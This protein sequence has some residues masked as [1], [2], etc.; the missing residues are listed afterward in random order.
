M[1]TVWKPEYELGI[2]TLDDDHKILVQHMNELETA[3]LVGQGKKALPELFHNLIEYTHMHFA[4]EEKIMQDRKFA[5]LAQHKKE[6]EEFLK[7]LRKFQQQ[8]N[9]GNIAVS[10]DVLNL[11]RDWLENHMLKSDKKLV[12][13]FR[14]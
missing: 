5:G 3:M 6:H 8:F 7:K 11:L 13:S 10:V 14:S 1:I 4:K 12:A 9:E 2:K